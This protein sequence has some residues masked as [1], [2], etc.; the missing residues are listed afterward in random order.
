MCT[1]MVR[2]FGE[3]HGIFRAS[4]LTAS[5]LVPLAKVAED[6]NLPIHRVDSFIK[7]K[8]LLASPFSMRAFTG[9]LTAVVAAYKSR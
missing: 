8:V 5:F 3:A 1:G 7:W 4:Q 6:L 9:M 2:A